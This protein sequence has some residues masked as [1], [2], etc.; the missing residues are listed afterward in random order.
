RSGRILVEG[1][2]VQELKLHQLRRSV[3]VIFQETFLFSASVAENISYGRP[4]ESGS[5]IERAARAA[6]AH[7]FICE[8]E[9]GY[10]T[11]IG[12]RGISLSGGQRQRVAI[13]R[14]FFTDPRILILDDATAS[15]D[16]KTERL[17]HEAMQRLCAGRTTFVIAQR[18]STVQHADL[19][20]VMKEGRILESG[21][22]EELVRRSG[23]YQEIFAQQILV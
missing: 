12:E 19:I 5:E 10:D 23:F 11:V 16:P 18:F 7:D 17:I 8:L 2:D 4:R 21:Q 9:D 3:S 6:Q 1:V 13:A 22:H 15:V 14:A 20:L